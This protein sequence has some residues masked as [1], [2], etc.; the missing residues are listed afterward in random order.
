METPYLTHISSE[1]FKYVY[2]PAE[3]SFLLLDALEADLA[4]LSAAKPTICT[5]IG[6][7]SGV[8]ITAVAKALPETAC[9]AIDINPRACDVTKR[10]AIKNAAAL[11]VVN[12]NLLNGFRL[13]TV[14]VLIFNPPYVVTPDE[15]IDPNDSMNDNPFNEKIIHSWAGGTDGRIIMDRVFN[16]MDSILSSGGVAYILVIEENKPKQIIE[17]MKTKGFLGTIVAERRIRGEHLYVIKFK[18][19]CSKC[20]DK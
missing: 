15:E 3:D 1:D 10:T 5:E 12:M 2:E 17:D 8:I 4:A 9:F 7:G 16:A 20:Q 11:N 13:N 19:N 18:R 6:S 14:D